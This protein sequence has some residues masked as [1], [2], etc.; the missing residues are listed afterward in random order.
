MICAEILKVLGNSTKFVFD[1]KQNVPRAI[2]GLNVDTNATAEMQQKFA[3]K[4]PGS[5]CQAVKKAILVLVAKYVSILS[6]I[7]YIM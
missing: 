4:R 5:A 1:S 7:D 2:M 3:Q 6:Y